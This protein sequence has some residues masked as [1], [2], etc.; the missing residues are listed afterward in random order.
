MKR[1]RLTK[2]GRLTKRERR[3]EHYRQQ[4]ADAR[5]AE[6]DRLNTECTAE[7]GRVRTVWLTREQMMD[8]YPM[9]EGQS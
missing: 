2:H 6:I 8:M 1:S 5:L 9:A 3:A 4:N 7:L